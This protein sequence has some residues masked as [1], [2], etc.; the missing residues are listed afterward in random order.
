MEDMFI[1]SGSYIEPLEV[2]IEPSDDLNE[3]RT[4]VHLPPPSPHSESGL[5]M[6]PYA[7]VHACMHI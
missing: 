3:P 2:K 7:Y 1:S 4:P 5:H 6:F